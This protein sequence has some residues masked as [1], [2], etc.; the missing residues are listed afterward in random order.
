MSC[1]SGWKNKECSNILVLFD[2][3]GTLTKARQEIEEDMHELLLKLKEKVVIG[4]VGGSD[5][6]KQQEQLRGKGSS[7]I[8]SI[9]EIWSSFSNSFFSLIPVSAL[10]IFDYGF[11]ENGLTA[12]KSGKLIHA[13]V[14]L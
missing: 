14:I 12:Y 2:V 4:F 1:Q 5:L 7:S 3:D 8:H 10:T 13:G 9:D 11:S 6:V